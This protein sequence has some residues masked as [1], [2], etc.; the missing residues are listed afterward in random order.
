VPQG[1]DF[2]SRL[3]D[4]FIMGVRFYSRIPVPVLPHEAPELNRIALALPFTSLAIGIV[5]AALLVILCFIGVPGI[6][7]AGLATVA[8]ILATGAMAEDALADSADGLGGGTTA[9]RRLE[10]MHDHTHGTYGVC[11]LVM[12]LLL[13]VVAVG[14]IAALSPLAAAGIWLA[15]MLL[16]R[17]GALWL[18]VALP[19]ARADG[20]SAAV[21]GVT[22]GAFG[23]GAVFAV[24]LSI[25]LAVPSA[26]ILALLVTLA[27]CAAVAL[28]WTLVSQR[29]V[30]GQ[31]GDLIGALQA[32]LEVAALT[33]FM[34][35]V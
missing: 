13:R 28:G 17:S 11:A 14:A 27:A 26:G 16:S 30:G 33:A 7:A 29:L 1:P 31:T 34:I 9:T 21:G 2:G 25:L 12:F 5:P 22:R 3:R 35:F 8:L 24:I 10:I 15:S 4:D 18:T 20:A 32:L 23:I 6:F 19:P